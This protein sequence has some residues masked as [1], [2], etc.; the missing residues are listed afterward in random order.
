MYRKAPE[1][2]GFHTGLR[3]AVRIIMLHVRVFLHQRRMLQI[4]RGRLI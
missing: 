3:L 1:H 4:V 2:F